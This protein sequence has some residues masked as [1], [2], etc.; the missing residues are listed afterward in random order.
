MATSAFKSTTKR[1]PI[2]TSQTSTTDDSS[3][4]ASRNSATHRR[5]RSL[6]RFSKRLS[7]QEFFPDEAPKG[8]F[9]NTVRGSGFP[10]ISLDD[11]AVEFFDSSGDRGRLSVRKDEPNDSRAGGGGTVRRGRSVSRQGAKGFSGN[12]SAGGKVVPESNNNPRRRRSVSV[13]RY[14]ISDSESDLDHSQ[15]TSNSASL[16]SNTSGN[17]QVPSLHRS[18]ASKHR[19]MLRRSVS[20]RDLKYHDDYSSQSSALTDDEGRDAPCIKNGIEN[21]IRVV[22]AQNKSDLDHSQ[23]SSNSASMKSNTSGNSLVPSL[24]RSGASNHRPM[25]RRSVSRRDL[26]DHGSYSNQS[27]TLTDDEGRDAPCSEK[28]IEKI[29][30]AVYAQNKVEHPTGN[31]LNGGLYD[32]M[33]KEFRHV[34]EEMRMEIEQAAVKTK[35]ST[36]PNNNGLPSKDFDALHSASTVRKNYAAQLEQSAKRKQDLL[37]EI[38]LE[39]HHSREL[40]KIVHGLL[41][42]ESKNSVVEKQARARKSNDRN[43]MSKR[44]TE[45]AEK[46]IEDFISSIEDTD[47]SSIDGERSDTSSILGGVTKTETFQ[48]PAISKPPTVQMDGVALPWL[49]W[50]TT[51]DASA[52]SSKTKTQPYSTSKTKFWDSSQKPK[53]AQDLSYHSASSR[54]SWSPEIID[55]H[56]MKFG[57]DIGNQSQKTRS[58]FDMDKYLKFQKDE[59]LLLEMLRQQQRINSGGM[60]LCN[61]MFI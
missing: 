46:Y 12:F 31:D 33:R 43:R 24:H 40:S 28:G 54:G 55:G 8:R 11:L 58:C 35:S 27:S 39:E 25:L 45:E 42:E 53:I 17:N 3:S 13:V 20:Q 26:K 18:S 2:A 60:L 41:P 44:L 38:L 16:K 4:S 48:S 30:R 21:I 7:G 52:Q 9:V 10:E 1:T 19:P 34:V 14:Q 61:Q 6:S 47:I 22:Y 36:L 37:A 49:Q 50:E 32:A 5:S 56:S 29:I 23:S 15:S 59:D 51:V 57:E